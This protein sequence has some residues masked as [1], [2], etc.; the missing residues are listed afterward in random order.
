MADSPPQ[1][2]AIGLKRYYRSGVQE[3]R[4]LDGVD[5]S[6]A[7]GEFVAIVGSSGSGKSTLLN[8]LGGLDTPTHGHIRVPQGD[9]STMPPRHKAR[10][11]AQDV[12]MIFQT[13]NLVSHRS[14]LANV[15]LALYF[16]DVKPRDR[17]H[18]SAQIL[19]QLGLKDRLHHRPADLSGG[20]QQRVAIARALVKNP[21]LLLADEP[22]GNLDRDNAQAITEIM[23]DWNRRGGT[24]IMVTHNLQLAEKHAH[25]IL[26]M[27]YGK[28]VENAGGPAP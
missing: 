8:L 3:V 13:F 7:K 24:V 4:A 22:T 21:A 1:L 10:Y 20:E 12:G 25:R 11:R 27:D 23:A 15:E 2:S 14:A 17:S 19:D 5:L 9:L 6:I 28:F 26:K 18:R 16:L